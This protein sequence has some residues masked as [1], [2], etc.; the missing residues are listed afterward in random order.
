MEVYRDRLIAY[1]LGNFA[2]YYGISVSGPK[3]FAPIL[4]V[5]VDGAGRFYHGEVV[6]AIQ[7]RPSGPRID[8]Q[9]RAYAMI[10]E[11]THLDF[12]GGGIHF[13]TDGR[14]TPEKLPGGPCDD[15]AEPGVFAP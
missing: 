12:N 7:L 13:Q 3:G 6:S 15:A 2:T 11:L 14:F 10:R 8:P 5:T 1:S 9:Q 4:R